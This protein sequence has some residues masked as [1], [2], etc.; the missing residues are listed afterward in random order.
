MVLPNV[1]LHTDFATHSLRP[2]GCASKLFEVLVWLLSRRRSLR[3]FNLKLGPQTLTRLAV[4]IWR[5]S[6]RVRWIKSTQLAI[7]YAYSK[8]VHHNWSFADIILCILLSIFYLHIVSNGIFSSSSYSIETT[9]KMRDARN[10]L[11]I[12]TF[13]DE[14]CILLISLVCCIF[15]QGFLSFLSVFLS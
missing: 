1:L 13:L 6:V 12:M 10:I 11:L 4:R 14:F 9:L 2:V 7:A 15:F 8:L 5:S 3:L